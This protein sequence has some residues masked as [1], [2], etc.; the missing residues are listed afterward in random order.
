MSDGKL[1]ETATS[2]ASGYS[3]DGFELDASA[4]SLPASAP[5]ATADATPTT[6]APPGEGKE[7]D[8]EDALIAA[9]LVP[10]PAPA[11]AAAEQTP[12]APQDAA[13]SQTPSAPQDAALSPGV[14]AT[15]DAQGAALPVPV[16]A[17]GPAIEHSA[18]A[19]PLVTS[20]PAAAEDAPQSVAPPVNTD[21]LPLNASE[22]VAHAIP[23]PPAP[24]TAISAAMTTTTSTPAAVSTPAP[25]ERA[26]AVAQTHSAV[27]AASDAISAPAAAPL[28]IA[29]LA[30]F[31]FAQY[32]APEGADARAAGWLPDTPLTGLLYIS[33]SEL[34]R[35][36][37]A[38][39]AASVAH[40]VSRWTAAFFHVA[41]GGAA[42]D[43]GGDAVAAIA[44]AV[45]YV[46]AGD[47]AV[48][49]LDGCAVAT[50]RACVGAPAFLSSG[51]PLGGGSGALS[52]V[53]FFALVGESIG[54]RAGES[55]ESAKAD[56]SAADSVTAAVAFL[57]LHA[58]A[59]TAAG[60]LST[61]LEVLLVATE[62]GAPPTAWRVESLAAAPDA[63]TAPLLRTPH[64]NALLSATGW[65]QK[66]GDDGAWTLRG[67]D[68]GATSPDALPVD[69]SIRLAASRDA[70]ENALTAS[71]GVP[72]LSRVIREAR[73]RVLT[74]DAAGAVGWITS[75]HKAVTAARAL[76]SAVIA[77]PRDI[78]LWRVP[79]ASPR[80]ATALITALGKDIAAAILAA[81]GFSVVGD[82]AILRGTAAWEPSAAVALAFPSDA[83]ASD[84]SPFEM[85][86]PMLPDEVRRS[87]CARKT[88]A[89][90]I[91][92]P[93]SPPPP[94]LPPP[95]PS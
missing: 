22:A 62:D 54:G 58:P 78:R 32:G 71:E 16:A 1:D 15:L 90:F 21:A 95:P 57:Q 44:R 42:A 47:A 55:S 59:S 33:L 29:Q 86:A 39:R 6:A 27:S 49:R 5:D 10:L 3:T 94:P 63:W 52:V 56:E 19:A 34:T 20:P 53:E 7:D 13:P 93:P 65:V 60:A 2:A 89:H 35:R 37:C 88:G 36:L 50:V 38:G 69:V 25:E 87:G 9:P 11:P 81:V 4:L 26:T 66:G 12:P 17:S 84:S 80:I 72:P 46:R 79:L 61:M 76:V 28:D 85:P 70:L 83:L 45:E 67:K 40:E 92:D 75:L 41:A 82:S 64:G 91:T 77:H 31:L 24:V 73:K 30:A 23:A 14:N 74:L 48:L 68:F 8:G 43:F 51:G 18:P